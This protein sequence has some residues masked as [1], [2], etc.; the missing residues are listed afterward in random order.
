MT[1]LSAQF[2]TRTRNAAVGSRDALLDEMRWLGEAARTPRIRTMADF[3]EAEIIL[4]EGPFRGLR[5]RTDR[6]PWARLWFEEIRCADLWRYYAL[7][8]CSQSGKSLH[9]YIVPGLYHLFEHV[10]T[11]GLGLP[12]LSMAQDKWEKDFFPVIEASRFRDLLPTKGAGSRGGRVKDSIMF[13]HG[14]IMRFFTAGGGDKSRAGYTTRVMIITEVDGL[15]TAGET[16]READKIRQLEARTVAYGQRA[17]IYKECTVSIDEGR[18]WQE[19]TGGTNSRIL[20]PCPA[21]AAWVKP[22]REHLVGWKEARSEAEAKALCHFV[23]PECGHAITDVERAV[24]NRSARLVHGASAEDGRR[25]LEEAEWKAHPGW[26]RARERSARRGSAAAAV[27]ATV[28]GAAAPETETLSLRYSAFNNLFWTSAELGQ[29]EWKAAREP[30]DRQDSADL[31]LRQ[32]FWVVPSKPAAS[33]VFDLTGEAI[34]A[35]TTREPRG[36]LPPDTRHFT[37]Y[38]DVGAWLC[39]WAAVAF[40]TD[41]SPHVVD[42]GALEVPTREVGEE[43]AIL[44]TLR[45]L[46]EDYCQP[47]WRT[48]SAAGEVGQRA[49][50]LVVA[51]ARYQGRKEDSFP[52]YEFVS[53]SSRLTNAAG[54]QRYLAAIGFSGTEYRSPRQ[55]GS[56]VAAIGERYH[57][58]R[59]VKGRHRVAL[60]EVDADH[61]KSWTHAR[62]TTPLGAP[63]AMTLFE[64]AEPATHAKLARHLTAEKKVEEFIPGSGPGKGMVTRWV[65]IH[66][67]NHLLDAVAGANMAGHFAGSRLEGT[68]APPTAA[69]PRAAA[70]RPRVTMPDGRPFLIT[71]R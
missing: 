15:D 17:R 39:H 41:G 26:E 33:A 19:L 35:R 6:Q 66:R 69:P 32:F 36:S 5:Y 71:E 23:C 8:G 18:I 12:D 4:P 27:E 56:G 31:E 30:I 67:D 47:G 7:T 9:G 45:R 64:A 40:R 2:T 46:R 25:V 58:M 13:R 37:V 55:L 3:A 22:E 61:W 44:L 10:E 49:P 68:Q 65:R 42:Y 43:R 51:D 34:L 16:S 24:M 70:P 62:L 54:K 1:T 52:V 14:V 53:E 21:C 50:D 29:K 48:V 38:C 57:L 60:L 11:V 59:A 28:W 63:G 20:C